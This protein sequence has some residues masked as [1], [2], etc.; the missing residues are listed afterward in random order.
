MKRY[1]IALILFFSLTKDESAQCPNAAFI[2]PDTV[3]A[4]EMIFP[5]NISTNATNYDW[6]FSCGDL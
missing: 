2:I 6:D 3:C 4:G 5:Q 1:I